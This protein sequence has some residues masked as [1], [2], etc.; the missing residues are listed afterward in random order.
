MRQNILL[1]VILLHNYRIYNCEKNPSLKENNRLEIK[2]NI[3]YRKK[4]F[5][6]LCFNELKTIDALILTI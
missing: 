5:I 2:P 4:I 6:M 3:I 1:F